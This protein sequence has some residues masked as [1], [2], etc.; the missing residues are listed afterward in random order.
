M[1]THVAAGR[2]AFTLIEILVV[3]GI[4]GLLMG[5]LLPT[6]E[7]ARHKGYIQ[8]C[9][10][11]LRQIGQALSIYSNENHG[12]Y[13]RTAYVAGQAP[14]AGSAAAGVTD[15]LALPANDVTAPL[16]LLARAEHLP[17]QVFMCPYNDVNEFEADKGDPQK[18]ANFTN[19]AKNLGYSY[20]NPYPDAAAVSKGYKLTNKVPA[21]FTLMADLNPGVSANRKSDVFLPNPKSPTTEMRYGNSE[22]H[23]REGQNV[24]FADGHVT[25]SLTP[26]V[27]I[28]DDNVYTSQAAAKPTVMASPAGPGDSVLLPVD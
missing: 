5:F 3:I 28:G 20:A 23:E 7:K 24:L 14:V 16:W 12:F 10:S 1:V 11:N 4:I 2:R 19:Y 27:G 6:M 9:A 17:T 21:G 8:A 18:Q 22:N 13:P 25:Y 15:P 26:F